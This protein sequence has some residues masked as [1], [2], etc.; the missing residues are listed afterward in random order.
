MTER[1]K[2]LAG[3]NTGHIRNADMEHLQTI[4]EITHQTI[5]EIYPRYYPKG[6]VDFFHAHHNDETI[7]RDLQAKDVY[8]I[9]NEEQIPVGTITIKAD[10]IFR[11]FVLP[12]Y[13]RKGFGRRLMDFA[14]NKIFKQHERCV[15]DAS[16][17]AKPIYL[18][19]G[20]TET[21]THSIPTES[22]DFLC[23]DVMEKCRKP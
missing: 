9:F 12:Q 21:E 18:K 1:E 10:E 16:L 5:A 23:Y 2:M 4:K 7:S 17:P 15:I 11:L 3:N 8:L 14:E 20:Y 19:R 6:A 13:Q 22:G